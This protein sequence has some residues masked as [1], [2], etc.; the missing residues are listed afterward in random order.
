MTSLV[1]SLLPG[2]QFTPLQGLPR[3]EAR[4]NDHVMM[5]F[6]APNKMLPA[7]DRN[8][9]VRGLAAR[10]CSAGCTLRSDQDQE[11]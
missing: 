4:P 2:H 5:M 6:Y 1:H 11:L 9:L 8:N 10:A 3:R 7:K